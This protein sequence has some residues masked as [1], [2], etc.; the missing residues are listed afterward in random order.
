MGDKPR[1][2]EVES[3]SRLDL[4][5]NGING[6]LNVIASRI[7]PANKDKSLHQ[8]LDAINTSIQSGFAA[9]AAEI[10][11]LQTPEPPP[12]KS[13]G[14]IVARFK[15]PADNPDFQ[16]QLTG[17]GF[18]DSEGNPAGAGDI[19][20]AVESSNPDAVAV[21]VAD[22]KVSDDGQSVT[23]T[24]SVHVGA[25]AA[26]AAAVNYKAT[27]RDTGALVASG[28]DEFIVQ[29]G[30]ASVGTITSSVPLTPEA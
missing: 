2:I 25:P 13:K 10:A 28:A 22:Q 16:I 15:V 27:N 12:A 21:S 24:V 29:A 1:V 23:A 18:T 6:A 11:K 7:G 5:L 14:V 26:D 9:V 4:L 30:E 20:L 8:A 19:D 3:R 17:S